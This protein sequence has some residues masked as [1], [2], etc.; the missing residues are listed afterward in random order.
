MAGAVF[1][2]PFLESNADAALKIAL[3]IVG[4]PLSAS[5]APCSCPCL[6]LSGR[7]LSA[8]LGGDQVPELRGR[9]GTRLWP[10][11]IREAT[12]P[13]QQQGSTRRSRNRRAAA[14]A[15]RAKQTQ[16]H[17]TS[18]RCATYQTHAGALGRARGRSP[19]EYK[20][21]QFTCPAGWRQGRRSWWGPAMG[22]AVRGGRERKDA[23]GWGRRVGR[24]GVRGKGGGGKRSRGCV[25]HTAS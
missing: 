23:I 7:A 25:N 11:Y 9:S 21:I 14:A 24:R 1:F 16:K 5:P 18:A 17:K 8:S 6:P 15:A 22:D 13:Q 4:G 3:N 19:P 10:Q 20:R 12:Q 2:E